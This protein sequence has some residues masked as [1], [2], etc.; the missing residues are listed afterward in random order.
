[1]FAYTLVYCKLL[2]VARNRLAFQSD[3]RVCTLYKSGNTRCKE[4]WALIKYAPPLLQ[5]QLSTDLL[6]Q[7]TKI[8]LNCISAIEVWRNSK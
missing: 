1:M 8:C 5:S 4:Y 2:K 6:K 7:P 3:C